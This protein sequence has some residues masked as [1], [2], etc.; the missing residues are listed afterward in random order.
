[1]YLHVD[2]LKSLQGVLN[3]KIRNVENRHLKLRL[4]THVCTKTTIDDIISSL[5]V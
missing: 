5:E 4:E 3:R 2:N 1:M